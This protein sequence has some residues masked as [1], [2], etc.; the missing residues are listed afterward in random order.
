MLKDV[1]DSK[2]LNLIFMTYTTLL[3]H[4]TFLIKYHDFL[5]SEIRNKIHLCDLWIDLDFDFI[6]GDINI[7]LSSC[8]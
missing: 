4:L 7:V 6:K 8:N 3:L 2:L 5:G 1:L